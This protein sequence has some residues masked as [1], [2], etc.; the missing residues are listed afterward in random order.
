[1]RTDR[2]LCWCAALVVAALPGCSDDDVV[3]DAG[4]GAD[5]AVDAPA[6]GDGPPSDALV[7]DAVGLPDLPPASTCAPGTRTGKA[8]A[9]NDL[10]TTAGVLYNV[11]APSSYDPTRG[12]PLLVVYAAAGG[13]RN[14][15]ETFTK[16]TASANPRGYIVA[17]VDH[18]SPASASAVD[19]I[20]Q[21]PTLVAKTWCVD[22]ARVYMTGHSDGGSVIYLLLAR[23]TWGIRPAAIAPSAAGVSGNTVKQI[24]CLE[25]PLPT[26]VIHSKNDSLFPGFGAQVKD[27]WYG[28]N[29]C[30]AWSTVSGCKVASGCKDGAEVQYCETSGSHGQWPGLNS[31]MMAFF[32]RFANVGP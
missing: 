20:G 24:S 27:W 21:V 11:R 19:G 30:S 31:Q 6:G 17:Y 28:C 10:S 14:N 15:M 7:V 25:K 26:M 16:L 8:G 23:N 2:W 29:G 1:M 5:A 18:V 9:T 12:H 4:G 3:Q 22:P 32:Q 13:N